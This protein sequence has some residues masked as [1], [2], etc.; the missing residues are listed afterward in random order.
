MPHSENNPDINRSRR[1][2]PREI[3]QEACDR[4]TPI[5]VVRPEQAGR[6]PMARGRLLKLSDDGLDIDKVQIPGREIRFH[7]GDKLE[8]FFSIGRTLYHFKTELLAA[9]EPKRLNR[10]M[11]IMGMSITVPPR[12]EQGDRRTLFRVPLGGREERVLVEVWKPVVEHDDDP[13]AWNEEEH[14]GEDSQQAMPSYAFNILNLH[15]DQ[16]L[17]EMD[18][19]PDYT[20]WVVDASEHGFG[21]RLEYVPPDRFRVF[22]PLVIRVTVPGEVGEIVHLC[23]IR[24]RRAVGEDGTRLGV[25]VIKEA[26]QS[27]SREKTARIRGFLNEVQREQLRRMRNRAG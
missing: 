11:V 6:V 17:G 9:S 2:V 21:L 3:L 12:I 15:L 23:E 27:A 24:A 25:V 18:R 10:R 1:V 13:A 26:D 5:C 22:E 4:N 14:D 16:L 19:L 20:G 8:A 7:R